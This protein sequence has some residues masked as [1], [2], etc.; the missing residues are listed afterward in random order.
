MS[1]IKYF[2]EFYK[3]D[4]SKEAN[5]VLSLARLQLIKNPTMF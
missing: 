1:L 4:P 3:E 2:Q 5:K